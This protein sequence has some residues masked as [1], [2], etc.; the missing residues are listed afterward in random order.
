MLEVLLDLSRAVARIRGPGLGTGFLIADD[1]LMTNHHVIATAEVAEQCVFEFN[2]QLDRHGKELAPLRCARALPAGR[3]SSERL[4]R[5]P[6]RLAAP[7]AS[8][9]RTR[10]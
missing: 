3:S 2:Y 5:A 10:E 6:A 9:V 8:R 4:G 1:L 7:R